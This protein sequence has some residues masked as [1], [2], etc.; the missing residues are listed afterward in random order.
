MIVNGYG[1]YFG[2]NESVLIP[3]C[4]MVAQLCTYTK[5]H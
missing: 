5:K 2:G 3:G 1:A 4:D